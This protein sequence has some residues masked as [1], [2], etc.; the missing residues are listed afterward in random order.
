MSDDLDDARPITVPVPGSDLARRLDARRRA[1]L[2]DPDW[3]LSRAQ[4]EN[5]AELLGAVRAALHDPYFGAKRGIG[6]T[7]RA[8]RRLVLLEHMGWSPFGRDRLIQERDRL[9]R[10]LYGAAPPT[11]FAD[12]LSLIDPKTRTLTRVRTFR[13]VIHMML[14]GGA[15]A[16]V[17]HSLPLLLCVLTVVVGL[18]GVATCRVASNSMRLSFRQLLPE[19]GDVL[20]IDPEEASYSLARTVDHDV[21]TIVDARVGLDLSD[22]AALVSE[23]D[24]IVAE[25][26]DMGTRRRRLE[27]IAP[28]TDEANAPDHAQLMQELDQWQSQL[29]RDAELIAEQAADAR[30]SIESAERERRQADARAELD[31]LAAPPPRM[32]QKRSD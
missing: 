16:I 21:A 32:I 13:T 20:T 25:L 9:S 19:G 11:R 27:A 14:V 4:R 26:A 7:E 17:F 6:L 24:R 12:A 23:R 30:E 31:E 28:D 2:A 8:A 3:T 15:S 29:R 18:V 5:G 1:G 22:R 10:S